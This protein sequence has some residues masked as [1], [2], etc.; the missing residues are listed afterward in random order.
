V[1]GSGS[2]LSCLPALHCTALRST[3][4]PAPDMDCRLH[5][6]RRR[7]K[8][9]MAIS[10]QS[11]PPQTPWHMSREASRP[12]PDSAS[13]QCSPAGNCSGTPFSRARPRAIFTAPQN[14]LDS[15]KSH[16]LTPG[17]HRLKIT[18]WYHVPKISPVRSSLPQKVDSVCGSGRPMGGAGPPWQGHQPPPPRSPQ[19][20]LPPQPEGHLERG[21]E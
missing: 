8:P 13:A 15:Y 20:Q 7:T 18:L 11:L 6:V 2:V 19:G 17:L 3:A 16:C 10:R 1:Q 12:G 14:G 21:C 4:P 5:S 9:A